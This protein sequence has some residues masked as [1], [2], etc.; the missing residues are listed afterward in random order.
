[1]KRMLINATQPEE[2]RVALVDGQ[3]L[4]DLDIESGAREQKKANIYKG[5]ITR[6][7]PSLEAAFVDFGAE[8]HGFLP[9]KEI[10]R[11]YFK[12]SPEG[13]INIKEVLSEGQE[14]IVQVEKEERGNKGAALTTFISLAGRYLV[15]MPNNPRAGGISRRIEGEERNELREALNGLNA[16]ADM[17]LIVR[18]AGLGRSTEELQWDLDYLL[19]LWSAIKEASGERGAPFLIYQESN[20]IIRAIRDY[21]RQ[22]IGEVLIDSIDAQEEALNFIRQVM[23]QYASKVKLYQDSVPL[24]NRF[25]IESQIETA[26]QREVKLPSGGSIVIDP[27]EALVSIDINSARAT[28]GGDIEE[29]ALQTNLEAAEEI[30]R[31]LRLRDIGGLIVIDFIDMTPAKNQR[32]VEE[33]VREALEADRAR[34]QVGRI[35]RFGLLEMSRQRLRPSL[36]E[37]SGIVCPR[38]NG[39]GI[40]RD[41][42]SL[43][44][45]ILRLIEEEALKDR[46]AEVRA[47]VPFQVAAFLLNEKR[48][49]ITK[50]ELRT[51]AR[52]FILPD[53]H[54]E[55]PHFEVQ[56]LRDDSPELVAGQTSYE[57]ATVE[58]E[59]AQPVSSTRT[60]VRQ[61][62]AV[63]T[64]APQQPAPQHT[65][66][67]VEPAKPMPEPSL[68]QGLVKS[69]VGLFAGKDQPAAKP[70]E[71][72][73]PAAE[74]QTRQDER[75]NGRQQNRRRD[76]RDGNRRDEERKPREERAERQPREE[77]AERPNREERSERRREER[78]ERP[79]REERQ[80]RE[81][82]E[83]RAERTPREERQPREGREGRE[84]R[85]ERRREER[86]ERPAREERQPREGREERAERPAREE[87][88]PREDR[89]AR[90]AA[91]L[92]AEALPNDESLEQDEQ[93]DTDGERPRRRSRGQRRRSNRRERQRE[94]SGELEGSEA[95][96]NAAA[97]L[98]TVAAAA[99]AGIAVASEA[100]EAN[101]EQAPATTSEAASET[102]ASD[103]TDASTSEAVETQGADS[104]ANTGETADIEAPVTVSVVR[105]EADQS[106]LLVAQ[107]TEEA[108]FASESVESREDAESAVQPAT[109]AAEEVAAPVPVEVAAPSEPA[110][111]EEPTPAI[112][113]VPANA[114]GRA[115]NDPREKR[116]LQREAERLAREAAA[117][118][119][120][121]AQAAPAV[122]EIPAVASEEASA[123]EEPAAPQAEE[124]TQADVPSQADEAQEAVQ[125]EPEASGEGAADT[126]HAKK[127]EESETSRPHA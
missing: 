58:H 117:A 60:L 25:Q 125:A 100:V 42:E 15:L 116:R 50:I 31:Q 29:T 47:R 122:E 85:S 55:T 113:A 6:V 69:L 120:A 95:T 68:F 4:F 89:Q 75:R 78:A 18:T 2:L 7:E 61:E 19:Q 56:R 35:S 45:A 20:V 86:A 65:E 12:K 90:D 8:R 66:A 97:P 30:A 22:D 1:M 74:R 52:I 40:I 115:L 39:Q 102:T 36:G 83:E 63:K 76:G 99:A 84:E 127:T 11:E 70:A 37:T 108:P 9:L 54:L 91:A 28:K 24:F 59:E 27:T 32:A 93:D 48:N 46:T 121:A 80:P 71:T 110:A 49:A 73:K 21:L 3:R 81:G 105:D 53:D 26:F 101:V 114:T 33:R 34:V 112:A 87:R 16:P 10:S 14:V 62:A 98:N 94:V 109:E 43:S 119:E 44:L 104:E 123:Q 38:C 13:R 57:M 92:E 41:V 103:E 72:S 111:T 88:Q 126:E 64:V 67:P 106:T 118:A 96:D 124:I 79:A 77:R 17:G 107:A 23:P 82:R 51:R 5:R